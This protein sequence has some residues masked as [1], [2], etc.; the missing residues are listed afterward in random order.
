M[1]SSNKKT[2]INSKIFFKKCFT[3][4]KL[5]LIEYNECLSVKAENKKFGYKVQSVVEEKIKQKGT[6]NWHFWY[7]QK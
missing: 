7:S 2:Y 1:W 3:Y 4:L 6:K 5:S